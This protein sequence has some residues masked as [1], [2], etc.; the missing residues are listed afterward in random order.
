MQLKL[1][2]VHTSNIIIACLLSVDIIKEYNPNLRGY[3][4][5]TGDEN[6]EEANMNVAVSGGISQ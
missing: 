4:I 2:G 6:S 3:S 1:K 5:D